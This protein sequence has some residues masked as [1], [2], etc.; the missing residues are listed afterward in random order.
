MAGTF[1]ALWPAGTFRTGAAAPQLDGTA[2]LA[3]TLE[4]A[5]AGL[6]RPVGTSYETHWTRLLALQ[7]PAEE[8]ATTGR[9]PGGEKAAAAG[10]QNW[11]DGKYHPL[12]FRPSRCSALVW[13]HPDRLSPVLGCAQAQEQ[14]PGRRRTTAR[15]RLLGPASR[16]GGG[17]AGRVCPGLPKRFWPLGRAGNWGPRGGVGSCCLPP[18]WWATPGRRGNDPAE[19]SP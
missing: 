5:V 9:K 10:E 6:A 17:E 7:R 4:T 2:L 18:P 13:W 15:G 1:A 12:R 16:R 11:G 3:G 14:A 19:G 8:A